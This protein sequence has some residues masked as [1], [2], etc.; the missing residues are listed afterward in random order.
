MKLEIDEIFDARYELLNLLGRGGFSEVWLA[1]DTKTGL[2]VALK[3]YAPG[4]GMDDDGV[5]LFMQEYSLV[6]NLKHPNLLRPSHF[7]DHNRMPY[8][9]MPYCERGSAQRLIG[10]ISEEEIWK[11]LHDV[12]GGLAYIH[13]QE[14]PILHQDIKPDNI[15]IDKLGNYLIT[16]FGISTRVRS[17]L[18]R[19]AMKNESAGGTRGFMAPERFSAD[20]RPVKAND[21]WSLGATLYE[22][23]SEDTPFGDE[24]GLLQHL[25]SEL[26]TIY[27]E[28]SNNLKQL[29]YACLAKD[30]WERPTAQQIYEYTSSYINGRR[31]PFRFKSSGA[32]AANNGDDARKTVRK[33]VGDTPPSK[34]KSTVKKTQTEKKK[35]NTPL[36]LVLVLIV[37]GGAMFGYNRYSANLLYEKELA[38]ARQ[39]IKAKVKQ[40]SLKRVYA[41]KARQD[42]IKSAEAERLEKKRRADEAK[43]LQKIK[44]ENDKLAKERAAQEEARIARE[45]ALK[46]EQERIAREKAAIEE[47]ERLAREKAERER[48][49]KI[50]E[51]KAELERAERELERIKKTQPNAAIENVWV[52]HNVMSGLIKGMKIHVKFTV[53]NMLQK[54]GACSVYFY[55][56][57]GTPLNDYNGNYKTTDGKVAVSMSYKPTYNDAIFNDLWV[58]MPYTEF[59]L[60][61]GAH[62]IQFDVIIYDNNSNQLA[63]CEPISLTYTNY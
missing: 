18:R 21:I 56:S 6:Y 31:E 5:Q 4:V 62:N 36:I 61:K 41:E 40:D 55:F 11:L 54:T 2:K 22:L 13:S 52:D 20:K 3:I 57:N 24:G 14:P 37:L 35:N 63:R 50:A 60:A 47:R 17:T 12:A 32:Q 43:A 16:D 51:A 9:V 29:V 48:L 39:E 1:N 8:L 58:F 25:G 38:I 26:P 45:K 30:T 34:P 33:V 42:S 46:V 15:L 44:E 49:A 27:A 19:S 28:V 23:I 10:K 53:N 59:H 7:D